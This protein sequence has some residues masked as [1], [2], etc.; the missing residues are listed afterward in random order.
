[1]RSVGGKWKLVGLVSL[2]EEHQVMKTI[3][4]G[5]YIPQLYL[6][7]IKPNTSAQSSLL[8]MQIYFCY[9]T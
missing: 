7:F 6:T 5:H 8:T 4:A 1:M 9:K 2:G 3:I